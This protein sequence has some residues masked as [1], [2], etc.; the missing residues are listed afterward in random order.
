MSNCIITL[1]GKKYYEDDFIDLLGLSVLNKEVILSNKRVI[2]SDSLLGKLSE[3]SSIESDTKSV[4]LEKDGTVVI[5]TKDGTI[6][7]SK[8][9]MLA[10]IKERSK[11]EPSSKE[12]EKEMIDLHS[13]L[14]QSID[15]N[16]KIPW[17]VILIGNLKKNKK[18]FYSKIEHE[19]TFKLARSYGIVPVVYNAS[20]SKFYVWESQ[21]GAFK[22]ADT[23]D[24][25]LLEDDMLDI[26]TDNLKNEADM[27]N[28]MSALKDKLFNSKHLDEDPISNLNKNIYERFLKNKSE[29]GVTTRATEN[30]V[31]P[32]YG[33]IRS[34][35]GND[36]STEDLIKATIKLFNDPNF[37]ENILSSTYSYEELK[38][39]DIRYRTSQEKEIA[40]V[41]YYL[42][43]E[44]KSLYD[45]RGSFDAFDDSD[46]LNA[47][48]KEKKELISNG[49]F[50]YEDKTDGEKSIS[51]DEGS[52]TFEQN[53][54]KLFEKGKIRKTVIITNNFG[55]ELRN[56]EVRRIL[57]E[58]KIVGND[59]E[60]F[61]EGDLVTIE[62]VDY[63][64]N[65]VKEVFR[66]EISYF[67]V[68][69]I[70]S[71]G[72][73]SNVYFYNDEEKE[74]K[75]IFS[76]SYSKESAK[77]ATD[78]ESNNN[79]KFI[80]SPRST[81]EANYSYAKTINEVKNSSHESV[82]ASDDELEGNENV[83]L[84]DKSSK[85]LLISK[86][87]FNTIVA[88]EDGNIYPVSGKMHPSDFIYTMLQGKKLIIDLSQVNENTA[89]LLGALE[90]FEEAYADVL[91][92]EKN[93]LDTDRVVFYFTERFTDEELEANNIDKKVF[94]ENALK[95]FNTVRIDNKTVTS[96]QALNPYNSNINPS[97]RHSPDNISPSRY[98]EANRRVRPPITDSFAEFRNFKRQILNEV[99]ENINKLSKDRSD[100][101]KNID[102]LNKKISKLYLMKSGLENDLAI[103][104]QEEEDNLF[105]VL[106]STMEG[107]L[108]TLKNIDRFEVQ[109]F[110]ERLDFIYEFITGLKF[111]DNKPSNS[112]NIAYSD[113]KD[114]DYTN[115]FASTLVKAY[116]KKLNEIAIEVMEGDINYFN[117]V[118]NN[119]R[120]TPEEMDKLLKVKSDI[121]FWE[122]YFLGTGLSSNF[123]S[124]VPQTI[125]S[126]LETANF[127]EMNRSYAMKEKLRD[128]FVKM[129]DRD[130][131]KFFE[132]SSI[133]ALTGNLIDYTS[134]KYREAL[135]E[136]YSIENMK[137]V[138]SYFQRQRMK[139][140][141]LDKHAEVIDIRKIKSLR[142]K[143][144]DD[145]DP[146]NVLFRFSDIE[147][148]E[149]ENQLRKKLG[150]MYDIIVSKAFD[151]MDNYLSTISNLDPSLTDSQIQE[152]VYRNNP[153]YFINNYFEGNSRVLTY[154]DVTTGETKK[155]LP[156]VGNIAFI[157]K[158]EI[159]K[160]YHPKT[161]AKIY[162]SSG[163]YNDEFKNKIESDEATFEFWK[164]I[165]E[166]YTNYINP[167]YDLYGMSFGKFD[168]SIA[169]LYSENSN[170]VTGG[171]E[172]VREM[173]NLITKWF[174]QEENYDIS[175]EGVTSNYSDRSIGE[176]RKMI[177]ILSSYDKE[178]IFKE[179]R[180]LGLS[181]N[182]S[183][184]DMQSLIRDVAT[185]SV[186]MNYSKDILLITNALLD[187][188][189]LQR[190]RTE[191]A[192]VADLLLEFFKTIKDDNGNVRKRA[193][194]KLQ[195]YV[196]VVV[197]NRPSLENKSHSIFDQSISDTK[198]MKGLAKGISK[199]PL[200]HFFVDENTPKMM[201]KSEKKIF[202][203]LKELHQKGF[204]KDNEYVIEMEDATYKR[205]KDENS[206][207][208]TFKTDEAGNVTLISDEEFNEVF[209]KDIERQ[210]NELGLDITAKGVINGVMKTL[211]A[212]SLGLSPV[213]GLRNR[214]EGR[215]TNMINDE[216]GE[217]WTPGNYA[218]ASRFMNFANA[219]KL[220]EK[221]FFNDSKNKH[222]NELKKAFVLF[223][224]LA[225]MQDR[226]DVLEKNVNDT[227]YKL[228]RLEGLYYSWS[229]EHP[230]FKN[231]GEAI[232]AVLGDMK[233][234]NKRT[235]EYEPIFDLD[236]GEFKMYD[237]VDNNLVLKEDYRTEENIRNWENFNVDRENLANNSMFLAISKA[238]FAVSSTQGNYEKL[239]TVMA[240]QN[241]MLK[242]V[243]LFKRWFANHYQQRFASGEGLS[244]ITG[245]KN[246]RG[247]YR[248]V[249]DNNGALVPAVL[250]NTA[251]A[252]GTGTVGAVVGG[253][254]GVFALYNIFEN[255]RNKNNRMNNYL[256]L[257]ESLS[258]IT[259][260]IINSVNFPFEFAFDKRLLKREW[261]GYGKT[262]LTPEMVGG[263]RATAKE[264]AVQLN[265][266]LIGT[267]VAKMFKYFDDDDDDMDDQFSNFVINEIHNYLNNYRVF[268]DPSLLITDQANMA[269]LRWVKGVGKLTKAM[270]ERDFGGATYTALKDLSAAPRTLV[271]FVGEGAVP[272]F[273][274]KIFDKN[275]WY[276]KSSLIN[277]KEDLAET[278]I[279][280]ARKSY[281]D[282]LK[283]SF[284]DKYTNATEAQIKYKVDKEMLQLF[285]KISKSSKDPMKYQKALKN[286][287]DKGLIDDDSWF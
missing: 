138:K 266:I 112:F 5:N 184:V 240:S 77:K 284:A 94:Y 39:K 189:A 216:S 255:Y 84:L 115:R 109:N 79:I 159:L 35:V 148:E 124:V 46:S 80:N 218:K 126:Y 181:F 120:Y 156:Y 51:F 36:A 93:R 207:M 59:L 280:N 217:F 134:S 1:N 9:D 22:E 249:L 175:N 110:R 14:L 23:I 108:N 147:M 139:L 227:N 106:N 136:F 29:R 221:L 57:F 157:P 246:M 85:D 104:E 54:R 41:I 90:V 133:G 26:G 195:N 116:N 190:A 7:F 247:R 19:N 182:E 4:I 58:D 214:T 203:L 166:S 155:I 225:I 135:K 213:A 40:N 83:E 25:M 170:I 167:T 151:N 130:T 165:R 49:S 228:N 101:T 146:E 258:F 285:G 78:F 89:N 65:S 273:N 211:I 169:E 144:K 272:G 158:S 15:K 81:T 161:G 185:Q 119:K 220:G 16:Y 257:G 72:K 230:E 201:T 210:L 55:K 3:Q 160:G 173:S 67:N 105:F 269:V 98:Q 223:D 245:K 196:D 149:Y 20:D 127:E 206:V 88:D 268:Q 12:E 248:H 252:L 226:K 74:Y 121:T 278:E 162:E 256:S 66:G 286:Y 176:I 86:T 117:E 141:W 243:M 260:V 56:A 87:K 241:V 114:Y 71:K 259:S 53:V 262:R 8:E 140:K 281:R 61:Y 279:R 232:L 17:K 253:A 99:I 180:K 37:R 235:Q 91:K 177:N 154:T 233:I 128:A 50:S 282:E 261:D 275:E 44:E 100:K 38:G 131:E 229:I 95:E 270:W 33:I 129:K 73:K 251:V 188:T 197:R 6:L 267:I 70:D 254:V 244:P 123:D 277:S 222:I 283:A 113:H 48:E 274:D 2:G 60:A 28:Y 118:L 13:K 199:I 171:I 152:I 186:L 193:I 219:V 200:G 174:F 183:T 187:Q 212:S 264:I 47:F 52:S 132:K 11:L 122:Q 76:K 21:E 30:S 198:L 45:R 125:K 234:F 208:Q 43:N 168:K 153:L 34:I 63:A 242:P 202:F 24:S 62:G 27:Y 237:L 250:L 111:E 263:L 239:D 143:Y 209:K 205:L 10:D 215:L 265:I 145:F 224:R 18:G 164:T 96:E 192:P 287:K 191:T 64:V 142:D 69:L 31:L 172:A 97:E 194:E 238:K 107:M 92:L 236:K 276:L 178:S 82:L 32:R 68:E 231:Q 103:L 42:L 137:D 163:Y 204:S 271:K 179:A 75:N 150:K 102:E